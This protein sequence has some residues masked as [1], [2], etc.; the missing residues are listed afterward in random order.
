MDTLYT[1]WENITHDKTKRVDCLGLMDSA[2]AQSLGF[3]VLI[4][5][6]SGLGLRVYTE[7]HMILQEVVLGF[8]V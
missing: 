3:R 1:F 5:L 6:G 8:R 4:C 2:T 7:F